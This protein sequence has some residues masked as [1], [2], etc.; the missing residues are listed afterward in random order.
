MSNF[1]DVTMKLWFGFA[2]FNAYSSHT[3]KK[4]FM[5]E[6]LSCLGFALKQS[7]ME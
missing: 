1:L 6:V 3:Y 2:F 7:S 5:D 4:A